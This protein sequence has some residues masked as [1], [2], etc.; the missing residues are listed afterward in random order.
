MKIRS[1][2]AMVVLSLCGSVLGQSD[3]PYKLAV[4]VEDAEVMSGVDIPLNIKLTNLSGPD[5]K[6]CFW[7]GLGFEYYVHDSSGNLLKEREQKADPL[8]RFSGSEGDDRKTLRAGQSLADEGALSSHIFPG[9]TK[10]GTYTLQLGWGPELGETGEVVV[11]S[12]IITVTVT[13]RTP[14]TLKLSGYSE[15]AASTKGTNFVAKK[16]KY[17]G[18]SIQKFNISEH[19]IPCSTANNVFTGL[20][21]KFQYD[22]RDSNGTP[23]T[24]RA[25]SEPRNPYTN[26]DSYEPC[27]AGHSMA[28]GSLDLTK[29]F[30]LSQPGVYT[31]RV[32]QPVSENPLDGEVRSNKIT[33]TV[34]P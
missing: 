17:I 5:V 25:V 22:I 12:N 20:D 6:C 18:I 28:S 27:P 11:K 16:G 13:E 1:A 30:D 15:G 24:R 34:V 23:V 3:D 31:I 33:V 9:L 8:G 10:P 21:D 26:G 7:N 29:A 4:S 19:A 32:S 2:L 14:F